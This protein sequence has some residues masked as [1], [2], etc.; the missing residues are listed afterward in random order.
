MGP[1]LCLA[2]GRREEDE[3][4]SKALEVTFSASASFCGPS[5][6]TPRALWGEGPCLQPPARKPHACQPRLPPPLQGQA[7]PDLT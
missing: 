4:E 3:R 7:F 2:T 6:I 1:G 5:V